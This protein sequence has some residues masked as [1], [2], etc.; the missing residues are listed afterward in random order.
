MEL[1]LVEEQLLARPRVADDG[2]ADL[3]DPQAAAAGPFALHAGR[4]GMSASR[5]RPVVGVEEFLPGT[6]SPAKKLRM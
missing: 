5:P 1:D 6:S 3:A 2:L 4:G